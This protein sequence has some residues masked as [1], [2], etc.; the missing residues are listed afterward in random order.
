[1]KQIFPQDKGNG[2]YYPGYIIFVDGEILDSGN[3][4]D[5]C[6]VYGEHAD[7]HCVDRAVAVLGLPKTTSVEIRKIKIVAWE[8]SDGKE[9]CV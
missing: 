1:M 4:N 8:D 2:T 3:G 9:A 6:T 7:Q 5:D